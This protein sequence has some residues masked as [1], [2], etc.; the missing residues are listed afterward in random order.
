MAADSDVVSDALADSRYAADISKK[1]QVGMKS[2]NGD[3]TQFF[4]FSHVT[5]IPIIKSLFLPAA[6]QRLS[7]IV[8]Y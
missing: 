1:M 5:L 7:L 3:P 8:P 6:A 2:L 4:R